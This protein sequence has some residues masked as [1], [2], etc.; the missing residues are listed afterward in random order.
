MI[1][2]CN[3]ALIPEPE[4]TGRL[5]RLSQE[6]AGRAPALVQLDGGGARLALAPH[7]TLYQVP[8]PA[9][10]LAVMDQRLAAL[11]QAWAPQHL[12]ATGYAYN[13]GEGS[14]EIGYEVTDDLNT[15]QTQTIAALNPLRQELLLERDPGGNPVKALLQAPGMLGANIR[16]TGYAEVGDPRKDGLFRPHATLTWLAPGTRFDPAREGLPE[17]ATLSGGYRA[18]GAYALGPLGTCPQLLASH[19]LHASAPAY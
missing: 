9:A 8:I 18:V 13:E 11:A 5:G 1:V 16:A 19:P 3:I 14:L 12:T 10:Q 17:P 7:L 2:E 4:L 15:I 6:I